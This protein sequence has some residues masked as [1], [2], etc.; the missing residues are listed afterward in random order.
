MMVTGYLRSDGEAETDAA[1]LARAAALL[2]IILESG[3]RRPR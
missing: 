1:S 3:C 2:P